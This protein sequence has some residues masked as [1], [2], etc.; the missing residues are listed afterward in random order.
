MR[1][2]VTG[3][4]GFIGS[5]L[6]DRLLAE[7]HTVDVVD[8]L[9]TGTLANLADARANRD[10]EFSFHQLDVRDPALADLFVR[11]T[12]EVVY[13]LAGIADIPAS[14]AD[15]VRDADVHVLGGLQVLDA[16]RRAGVRKVVY[17]SSAA[18]YGAVDRSDLPLREAQRH[19]PATPY[20]ASTDA[21]GAYLAAYRELHDVE[22]T[23]LALSNVYGPRQGAGVVAAFAGRMVAGEP[24]TIYGDGT[25]TR[26][27]IYIDDVVDAL[28][29]AAN[30]GDGLL[31]NAGTAKP[32]S[33][34]ALYNL[35]AA[36]AAVTRRPTHGPAR[37][38][39]VSDSALDPGRAGIHLGWMPWTRL[40]E[41]IESIF[42]SLSR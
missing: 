3:G 40:A 20:G 7:G 31:L 11:R 4:A 30:R 19:Q 13:H 16:V 26:D 36:T 24:C 34:V 37:A 32:T 2:L 5:N 17:A 38:G 21:V 33:I 39:D 14:V 27:F 22:F 42:R 8:D 6:V 41:G 25:Q 9:S 29:R 23:A 35:M 28:A 10:H 1:V 18:I 15:A 12:P